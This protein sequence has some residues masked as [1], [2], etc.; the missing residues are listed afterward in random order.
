MKV[1]GFFTVLLAG[2]ALLLSAQNNEVGRDEAVRKFARKSLK[3]NKGEPGDTAWSTGGN[4][5]LNINQ[6]TY[7]NWQAGGVNSIA[8]NSLLSVFAN[9]DDG[10]K[11]K[12]SN[13]LSLAYGFAFQDT[14]FN[15]TDDRLEFE[16]RVDHSLS[17]KWNASG[18]LNFRTQFTNGFAQPG[19]AEDSLRIS[20]FMAP[21]YVVSGLG[22]TYK[23][24]KKFSATISPATS[25]MTF[26]LDDR[27]ANMGSFGVDTGKNYRQEIGG[28]L[29]LLFK[30]PIT[31]NIRMQSRLDMYAN[32]IEADYDFP[33]YN[34]EVVFYLKVNEY[35]N[36]N[37]T[38]NSIYDYDAKFQT[39]SGEEVERVQFKEV[40][41]VGFSYDFGDA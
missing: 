11:W 25:K 21:G 16:S 22:F 23:P 35:V 34:A 41:S 29:N 17:K 30:T 36:A 27:L 9:Y 5:S 32:Y 37:I 18:F 4:Y 7:S 26:V 14:V 33:D 19:Q 12:W 10:G 24:N 15:K 39:P 8:I 3:F 31:K 2:S 28:Y 13:S 1:Q 6:A 20:T 38:L 40:I